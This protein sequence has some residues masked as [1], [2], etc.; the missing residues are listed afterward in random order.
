[1]TA[2]TPWTGWLAKYDGAG[3][4]GRTPLAAASRRFWAVKNAPEGGD[5]ARTAEAGST[6]RAASRAC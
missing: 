2:L 1:M 5:P 6:D 3:A 4:E